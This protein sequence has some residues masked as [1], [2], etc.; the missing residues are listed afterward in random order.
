MKRII[1]L[2]SLAF[3]ALL[4]GTEASAQKY[5]TGPD[6]TECKKYLSY[7]NDYYKHRKT[8][9]ESYES[10]LVNWR[11]AYKY[12]PPSASYNMLT[13][14]IEFMRGLIKKNA[15]DKNYYN[16]LVDSLIFLQHQRLEQRPKNSVS[17]LNSLGTDMRNYFKNEPYK[18][19]QGLAEVVAKNGSKTQMVLFKDYVNA[20]CELYKDGI[21]EPEKVIEAYTTSV[22][23]LAQITPKNDTEKEF[24]ATNISEIETLFITS[25]VADCENLITLFTP[26]YEADPQNLD[27]AKNIVKMMGMTEGCMDNDLFL[28]AVTTMY[29]MEP[30]YTSA[31]NLYKLHSSKGDVAQAIKY[32]EEAI[33]YPES[34]NAVDADYMYQLAVFCSK[35]GEQVKAVK[36]AN[37]AIALDAAVAGKSYMLLGIIWGSAPCYPNGNEIEKRAKYWLAVDY[38]TKAKEA[39]PTLAEDANNYIGQ[40]KTFYPSTGDA[41]MYGYENGHTFYVEWNGFKVPTRVRTQN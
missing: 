28:A 6:S 19:Y 29:N 22:E 5:G 33:A 2:F 13:H 36:A 30:S 35:N 9:A 32:M 31:Y 34:D 10:A 23:C 39:D 41:F 11:K 1:L 26:R 14:G 25:Q 15:S 8:S 18:L 37:D 16:S 40:Y 21:L 3:V 7:Y 38:M 27:L 4:S 20:A 12:C 24:I 17:T